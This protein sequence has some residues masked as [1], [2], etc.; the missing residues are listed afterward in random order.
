MHYQLPPSPYQAAFSEIPWESES[1]SQIFR[2]TAAE[3]KL[4]KHADANPLEYILADVQEATAFCSLL[5]KLL[6][7]VTGPSSSIAA[8]LSQVS[9][10]GTTST[11]TTPDDISHW[12]QTDLSGILRH[13][14]LQ[15]L[16]EVL[17]ILSD[18]KASSTS[19]TISNLFYSPLDGS[20]TP[21]WRSLLRIL[22]LGGGTGDPFGQR[23]Y[24]AP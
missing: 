24:H 12:L 7:Q 3:K 13:V 11:T 1:V 23:K 14:C 5:L 21:E 4:W 19:I 17:G 2:W 9:Q 16:H 10:E 6:D 15:K 20:L 18:T 8:T 22:Y